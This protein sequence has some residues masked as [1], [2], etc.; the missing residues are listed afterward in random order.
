MRRGEGIIALPVEPVGS[1][2]DDQIL[3]GGT[4]GRQRGRCHAA[5]QNAFHVDPPMAL[6]G[7]FIPSLWRLSLP[8]GT[9]SPTLPKPPGPVKDAAALAPRGG[10]WLGWSP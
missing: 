2:C 7:A 1:R 3:G 5:H 10:F 4:A 9:V 8:A 6:T